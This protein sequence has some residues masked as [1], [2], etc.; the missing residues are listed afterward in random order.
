MKKLRYIKMMRDKKSPLVQRNCF[1]NVTEMVNFV[2]C[3]KEYCKF[4]E[5]M[6]LSFNVPLYTVPIQ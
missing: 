3:G 6:R 4:D 2:F 5:D 1:S